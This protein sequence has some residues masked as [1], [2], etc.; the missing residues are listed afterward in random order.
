MR[1]FAG[2]VATTDREVVRISNEKRIDDYLK[3]LEEPQRRTLG[4]L[5]R[6]IRE[7]EPDVE[8]T[9]SYGY[10]AFR[11]RGETIAGFA[12]FKKHLSYLPFSGSVLARI[13]KELDGF[14]MTDSS[15]HFPSNKPLSKALVK[16]LI[17]ARLEE[18]D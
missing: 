16:K 8:E 11:L 5:R 4:K 2:V 18:I 13:G 6:T 9:I 12:A 17:Q 7:V 15:L 3:G 1:R 10:P 14:E